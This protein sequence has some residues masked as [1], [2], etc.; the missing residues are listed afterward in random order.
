[1]GGC[2]VITADG[3]A[4]TPG[5]GE[6]DSEPDE[7]GPLRT[8]RVEP[9][10]CKALAAL[11]PSPELRAPPHARIAAQLRKLPRYNATDPDTR[12]A[13]DLTDNE[14]REAAAIIRAI[15]ALPAWPAMSYQG[16][17]GLRAA[18]GGYALDIADELD[19]RAGRNTQACWLAHGLE[20]P[21]R[22]SIQATRL[23]A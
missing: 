15:R 22:H 21:G 11:D 13:A 7:C 6:D 20:D 9:K 4:V 18:L 14:L 5:P 1:M 3:E 10:L 8:A 16:S 23:S 17:S 19:K 2:P 12:Q